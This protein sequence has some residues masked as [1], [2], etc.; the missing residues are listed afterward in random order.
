[1]TSYDT[2]CIMYTYN[3]PM[4]FLDYHHRYHNL[5]L[6]NHYDTDPTIN[7]HSNIMHRYYILHPARVPVLDDTLNIFVCLYVCNGANIIYCSKII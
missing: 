7:H 6:L 4:T 2:I 3:V 5:M 1:M